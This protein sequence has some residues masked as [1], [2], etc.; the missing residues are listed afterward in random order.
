MLCWVLRKLILGYLKYV[1]CT[2]KAKQDLKLNP[3]LLLLGY[4]L[5]TVVFFSI[6]VIAIVLH[7]AVCQLV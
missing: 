5:L 2:N 3:P 1:T 6:F 4:T 7:A